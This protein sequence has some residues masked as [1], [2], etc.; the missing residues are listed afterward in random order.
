MISFWRG[1]TKVRVP[2][3]ERAKARKQLVALYPKGTNMLDE[4]ADE[5]VDWYLEEH[6][7]IVLLFEVDVTEAVAP[8]VNCWEVEIDEPDRKVIRELQQA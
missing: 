8:Y 6:P 2:T 7:K 4:L 5:E 1:K 3:Q